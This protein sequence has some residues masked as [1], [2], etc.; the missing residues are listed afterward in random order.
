[1]W[2]KF[3]TCV[4]R[5]KA[6]C[7]LAPLAE[8]LLVF[9]GGYAAFAL[10]NFQQRQQEARRRDQILAALEHR[11][12]KSGREF[13]RGASVCKN[14]AR[15]HPSAPSLPPIAS[16]GHRP[17]QPRS[18]MAGQFRRAR[19]SNHTNGTFQTILP[20]F[21]QIAAI[22][23]AFNLVPPRISLISASRNSRPAVVIF[24]RRSSALEEIRPMISFVPG[25]SSAA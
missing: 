8:L 5:S 11:S 14:L 6:S 13:W 24:E 22:K 25:R 15:L 21:S 3:V 9:I 2:R 17:Q 1:M 19:H 7:K 23:N 12:R 10:N 4:L 16:H 20:V 18:R